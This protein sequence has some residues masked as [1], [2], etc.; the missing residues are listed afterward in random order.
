MKRRNLSL[1]LAAGALM[2]VST[3]S[4]FADSD[5]VFDFAVIPASLTTQAD[6][7]STYDRLIVEVAAYCDQ[8]GQGLDHRLCVSE[9]TDA[10]I[11]QI[12]NAALTEEHN[13]Q[14]ARPT[15]VASAD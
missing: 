4:V 1:A 10:T 13:R 6:I 12:D 14:K 5:N 7:Q 3:S 11:L 15:L 8:F 9:V 2:A